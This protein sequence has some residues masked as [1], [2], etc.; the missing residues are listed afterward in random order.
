MKAFC[1][2]F[3]RCAMSSQPSCLAKFFG[4]LVIGTANLYC[5]G[6]ITVMMPECVSDEEFAETYNAIKPTK[7]DDK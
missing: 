6:H 4:F 5:L 3:H 7:D 1:Y 2:R